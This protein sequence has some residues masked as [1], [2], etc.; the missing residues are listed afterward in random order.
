MDIFA[1]GFWAGAAG[2]GARRKLGRRIS[3]PW[4]VLWGVFPDLFAFSPTFVLV[5]W[6]RLF[7]GV[8][9]TGRF[10]IFSP[11]ARDA[12]PTLLRPDEL[13]HYS[14]SLV[15]FSLVF[16]AVWL[17]RRR[18]VLAMLAWPLHILMDI[19]SHRAG[20]FGTPFLWPLSSYVFDGTSWGQRWFMIL[21]WSAIAAAYL[22]LLLWYLASRGK[23]GRASGAR[24]VASGEEPAARSGALTSAR[25]ET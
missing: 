2:I 23:Q 8:A 4:A 17:W 10:L 1:H 15:V 16:G 25:R 14:H 3:L 7:E 9:F 21:N 13:Y 24:Q 22:A 11:A 18:P 5:L 20:R 12:L 19:P 6:L